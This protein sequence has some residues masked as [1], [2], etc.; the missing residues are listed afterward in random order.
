MRYF[1]ILLAVVL[2]FTASFAGDADKLAII[3]F[4]KDA[5]YFAFETYGVGDGSGLG[6]SDIYIIDI[7][8]NSWV[9]GSPIRQ[10]GEN[11]NQTQSVARA[12]ALKRAAPLL[13][14]Y[15]ID[16]SFEFL[17]ANP[18][19]EIVADRRRIEFDSIHRSYGNSAVTPGVAADNRFILSLTD[20]PMGANADCL[21]E[22]GA[23]HGFS[24]V[25]KQTLSGK[26][27]EAYKDAAVPTS[28]GCPYNYELEAIVSPEDESGSTV[29][30]AL[31][32]FY[33]QGFEG[34]DRH[35][36]AVPF[37]LP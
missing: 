25:I 14:K 7:K 12:A 31:V 4:S 1:T 22:D 34:P 21:S 30:V 16:Q 6:Y 17:A 24:L 8:S 32:A 29:L 11:E 10:R 23:R 19:T 20:F 28:R 18:I 36:I 3:G 2:N 26:N 15:K 33:T 5:S 9:E 35:F 27:L 37:T 13:E